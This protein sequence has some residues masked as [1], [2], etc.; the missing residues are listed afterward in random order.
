MKI[1]LIY[2]LIHAAGDTDNLSWKWN[3]WEEILAQQKIW[4]S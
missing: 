3:G 1:L 2:K 4:H